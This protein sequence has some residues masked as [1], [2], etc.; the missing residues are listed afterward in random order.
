[1]GGG[2]GGGGGGG[3]VLWGENPLD[4]SPAVGEDRY[5]VIGDDKRR[6]SPRKR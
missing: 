2:G 3:E 1:M 6:M 5:D 4:V